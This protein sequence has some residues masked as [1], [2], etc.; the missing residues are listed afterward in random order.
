MNEAARV[1]AIWVFQRGEMELNNFECPNCGA[2]NL[3]QD[4]RGRLTCTFCD[5]SF[6]EATRI[7]PNCGDYNEDGV[8]HCARCGTALVRDCPA[9]GADNWALAEHCV[10]C[11]R[12]LDVIEQMARRW[13]QTTRERLQ[14][15]RAGVAE[16]RANEESA[17]RRRM[18]VLMETE[19]A[20]QEALLKAQAVQRQRDRQM[21][22]MVA[23]SLAVFCLIVVVLLLLSLAGG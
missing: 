21:Y 14:Q 6:G 23:V 8:R 9:C 10:N 4:E 3:V 19:R 16:L 11:G 7:C 13:Q 17:T 5:S 1:A 15:W 20:R 18:A 12:S 22:V 2:K